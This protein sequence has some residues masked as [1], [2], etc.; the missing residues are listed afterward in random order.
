MLG[1]LNRWGHGRFRDLLSLYIDSRLD[2]SQAA[3]LEEHL[4]AC[5]PCREELQT[6]RATV[7]LLQA[8]PHATPRR[9]FSLTEQP[10]QVPRAAPAYLWGMR[11]ATA[12]ASILLVL[13]VA[14]DLLGTFS[15]DIAP[16]SEIIQ[17]TVEKDAFDADSPQF[18]SATGSV[19]R[20]LESEAAAPEADF[21]PSLE[22]PLLQTDASTE[23]T[24]PVT[25]L[26]I[27]FGSLLALLALVTLLA[28]LRYRRRSHPA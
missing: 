17:S 6:L 7:S 11:A 8:L 28:T 27:A 3:T 19:P 24:L 22:S 1:L 10:Q 4:A 25:A 26:E 12:T 14:G 20:T 9:S 18:E 21:A 23:E 15:R 5:A 13:L 2:D 16:T